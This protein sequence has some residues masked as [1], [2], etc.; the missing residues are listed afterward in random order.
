MW[1][2]VSE[3]KEIGNRMKSVNEK[4][5][6]SEELMESLKAHTSKIAVVGMG[7]VGLP[8]AVEF[9]RVGFDV[10]GLEVDQRRCEALCK[11]ESYIAD[12][13]D[14]DIMEVILQDAFHPSSDLNS[15]RESDVVLICV[16]TP[17]R[18]SKDPDLTAILSAGEAI[19]E[20]LHRGQLIILE[21][22]TYPGTTE[23]ILLPMFEEKGLKVGEDFFLAFSP[24]RID[25]GNPQFSVKNITK[26]VGGVTR[27]C[28]E[29]SATLYE[30]IVSKVVRVSSARVAE[31]SKLLEN[32]FR[33][34]NIA[35]MNEMSIICKHLDVDVWEVIDAAATKPFGFLPHYPGPGIGGH[36]IPLD[37]HYLSWKARLSGYEPRFIALASEING[38]M[39]HHVV[40]LVSEAL[41][42]SGKAIRGSNVVILGAAYKPNV[43]DFRESPSMEI[44]ELLIHK[45]AKLS[46][47]DPYVPEVK[48]GN[49]ILMAVE[50]NERTLSAADCVVVVTNH[51]DFDYEMIVRKSPVV[52]DTRN[53]T[54]K[55]AD[56]GKVYFL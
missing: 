38:A 31:A 3:V 24:E 10:T 1:R 28:T 37:P 42:D 14:S 44:M 22:T 45:G 6:L 7:Y 40:D 11:G 12:M 15:L 4:A 51:R 20:N 54:R 21:S 53:A 35:L 39:P 13:R 41:N 8:M 43:S 52:V 33:S 32:T 47:C 19:A 46:Y 55:F 17:L 36:C 23:E 25:P 2:R 50:S 5:S 29:L 26:L 16:P 27:M 56:L 9:A 34:V 18:K 49:D 48:V 30:Q